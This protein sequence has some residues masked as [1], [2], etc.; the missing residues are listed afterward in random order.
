MGGGDVFGPLEG[1]GEV[2]LY[3]IVSEDFVGGA[4]PYHH[5]ACGVDL[6]GSEGDA[7]G[8]KRGCGEGDC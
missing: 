2:D 1:R 7:A 3:F 4:D 6:G 5:C 8:R